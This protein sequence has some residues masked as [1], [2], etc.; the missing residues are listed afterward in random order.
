VCAWNGRALEGKGEVG[1]RTVPKVDNTVSAL[2]RAKGLCMPD[3]EALTGQMPKGRYSAPQVP[4]AELMA[5]WPALEAHDR[6]SAGGTRSGP[7]GR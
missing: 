3:F 4:A 6:W 2:I 5:C 1:S 7:R